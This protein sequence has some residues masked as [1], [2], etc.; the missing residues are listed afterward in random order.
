MFF[1]RMGGAGRGRIPDLSV[2]SV[3]V[4][5]LRSVIDIRYEGFRLYP[6]LSSSP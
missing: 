6:M 1:G 4:M 3:D 2:D 5:V